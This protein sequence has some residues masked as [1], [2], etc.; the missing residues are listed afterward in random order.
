MVLGE[1]SAP[2]SASATGKPI[3]AARSSSAHA[4]GGDAHARALPDGGLEVTV[5][6]PTH[7][8]RH[9]VTRGEVIG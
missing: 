4:H 7:A 5:Q 1:P 8:R 9:Q 2:S 6:L 3:S